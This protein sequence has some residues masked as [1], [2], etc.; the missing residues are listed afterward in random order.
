MNGSVKFFDSRQRYLL[1][2][3]TTNEKAVV[4]EKVSTIIENIK[5]Q[6]PALKIFDAGVGDGAVLMNVLRSCH[7]KFPT[8]P[9]L[10]SGKD[11][12]MEDARLTIEKLADRLVEHPNMVFVI[13]NLHYS[14]APFL[15]S[16]NAEKQKKMNWDVVKL[17]GNSSYG[18]NKQLSQLDNILK[19][20]WRVEENKSGN[21]TYELPSVIVI[22]RDDQEFALEQIIPTKE[23][24]INEFDLVLV[25]QAY[26]S[27][28]SVE[29]KIKFV[30]N[31]MIKCLSSGGKLAIFHSCGNDPGAE[32]IKRLWPD[33]NPFPNNAIDMIKY[34]KDNI[35][36]SDSENLIFN[37]PQE[38]KYHLRSQP[39]EINSGISTS[40]LFSA[41]NACTYVA[42]IS[43]EMVR[44]KESDQS[45]INC[46]GE[47]VKNNDGLWFNDEMLVIEKK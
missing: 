8:I 39:N 21:T 14:E 17:K 33:E 10:V 36:N 35:P 47:I 19:N 41:W 42:Q 30:I 43:D 45:Y 13:S 46:V 2:V 31:P 15:K 12:S 11:V 22:Y 28:F 25:S 34:L 32:V 1:F 3:T 27:R 23:K 5:P 29:K 4:S 37:K 9:F 16:N 26:R 44:E 18:F 24:S 40:L 38:F 6:K 20:N 7:Q